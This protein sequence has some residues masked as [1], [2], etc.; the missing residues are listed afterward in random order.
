[1]HTSHS[2]FKFFLLTKP[3][4]NQLWKSFAS[5]SMLKPRY[6]RHTVAT[7][8]SFFFIACDWN[9][10]DNKLSLPDIASTEWKIISDIPPPAGYKRMAVDSSSF[11]EWLRTISIKKDKKVFLYNGSLK[12]NQSAQFAVLDIPVGTKDLQQCAD[13]ILRLRAEYFL[14]MNQIHL[15]KFKATDGTLLS[16]ADWR[17]GTRY[18]LSGSKLLAYTSNT[19]QADIKKDMES[20]LEI[21]FSFCGTYSLKMET[22]TVDM[23]GMQPGYILVKG[24]SPGHAMIIM[25]IAV[26]DKGNKMFMLAQSYMPAQDIHIVKNPMDDTVSPWYELNDLQEIITPEW[27]FSNDQLRRW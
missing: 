10:K 19:T 17:K 2:L 16:F 27:T 15:I 14:E 8:L 6:M 18:K 13:A 22:R 20:F 5:D 11:G 25:D 24:G 7:F 23:T 4:A 1:M 12:R 3:K 26:N 9:Y 21:V